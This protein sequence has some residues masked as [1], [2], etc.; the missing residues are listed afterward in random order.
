MTH[1]L[2][3]NK[4]SLTYPDNKLRRTSIVPF[5]FPLHYY[6]PSSLSSSNIC[7]VRLTKQLKYTYLFGIQKTPG[8]GQ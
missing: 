1:Y 6:G 7:T 5:F 4:I 2:I 8:I 3:M